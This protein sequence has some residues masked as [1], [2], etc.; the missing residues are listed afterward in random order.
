MAGTTGSVIRGVM[1]LF[2]YTLGLGLP[3][4]IV[5]TFFGRASR[6]SLFCASFAERA[7]W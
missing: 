3:L 7:G 6:Q 2:I 5:S 4:I 1:L